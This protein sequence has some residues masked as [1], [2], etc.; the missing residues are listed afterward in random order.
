MLLRL[1]L[2][3]FF[4]VVAFSGFDSANMTPFMPLGIAGVVAAAGKLVFAYAGFDA[5]AVAG[6][7]PRIRAARFPSRSWVRS[8]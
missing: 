8:R 7:R 2:I 4:L 1:V 3:G 5:A 6:R